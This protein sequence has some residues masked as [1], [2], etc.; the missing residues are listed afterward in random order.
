MKVFAKLFLFFLLSASVL[1][2]QSSLTSL[3]GTVTDT[4]GAAVPGSL[5]TIENKAAAYHAERTADGTGGYQFLQLPPGTYSITA[6]GSGFAAQTAVA[7]LLVNQP[8]T[9]NLTLSVQ[10]TTVTMNVSGA[11]ETLNT[12]DAS[13]GNAVNNATIEALPMEGR[14][15][16]DLLSLQPGVL[17]LGHNINQNFD[18][19]SGAVAGSRSDQGNV[20]LDGVDNND[21]VNGYAFTG[22]LRST[23]DSVEEFRVTTTNANA[24]EGRSSGAQVSLVTRSGSNQLHGSLYEYN[25]NTITAANNW[26]NKQAQAA[27]GE[28]NIPG[29]LI[30]NTF[31]A[32]LGGPVKKDKVFY[33]L[34]YEGQRT[35]E[36]Q[37]ETAVVP[38][39]SYAAG[40]VSYTSGGQNVTLTR[41]QIAAMDPNC[42]GTGTC[43][44]GPGVDPYAL[45]TLVQYP[46]NN[47]FVT[48]DGLNTGSYTW[49][50]PNPTVLNTYIAK[51]DYVFL[52]VIDCLCAATCKTTVSCM[53]RCS[54]ASQQATNTLTIPRAS[55]RATRGR[56]P[57]TWSIACT[58]V[59]CARATPTVASGKDRTS[60]SA[61]RAAC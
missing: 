46:L 19:R 43:P 37:Q 39:A 24:N 16:P 3:R 42:H 25:R 10:A 20:T 35:A 7:E 55:R 58:T 29:K 27:A 1:C 48:G 5:V 45:Q 21:Q 56:L 41:A 52:T 14:N 40:N 18:S 17:Y 38:T 22:V 15:V 28:P 50:A 53:S 32:A 47:G 44:W 60:T 36:N 59:T 61:W 49:S 12:T 23:L 34:N 26:F 13:L 6:T 8:A 4:S 51:I 2:A 31:G 9:V 54:P 30:R 11:S 33:F 57:T